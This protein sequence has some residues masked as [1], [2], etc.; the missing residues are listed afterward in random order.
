[1]ADSHSWSVVL[2]LLVTATSISIIA[3]GLITVSP[4]LPRRVA[5]GDPLGFSIRKISRHAGL[6]CRTNFPCGLRRIQDAGRRSI[7]EQ[8]HPSAARRDQRH[9]PQRRDAVR[10][11][12]MRIAIRDRCSGGCF[13]RADDVVDF[14]KSSLRHKRLPIFD[15]KSAY[16]P[17][18]FLL[19]SSHRSLT[20]D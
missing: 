19:V 12:T 1:M 8:S 6:V 17:W 16:I 4:S 2:L 9:A 13:S 18:L 20:I 14:R 15:H 3:A 5:L 10:P 11:L 7:Y